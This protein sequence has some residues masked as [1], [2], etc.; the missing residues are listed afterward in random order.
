MGPHVFPPDSLLHRK[1]ENST[2]KCG[3]W[4]QRMLSTPSGTQLLPDP[5]RTSTPTRHSR[6]MPVM[7]QESTPV[8]LSTKIPSE[9][10]SVLERT[11]IPQEPPDARTENRDIYTLT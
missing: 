5:C 10:Q 7:P 9:Q 8:R 1:W 2:I 11:V 3:I 4:T 6:E